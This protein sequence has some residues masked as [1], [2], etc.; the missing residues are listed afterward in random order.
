[1]KKIVILLLLILSAATGNAQKVIAKANIN[2]R[3]APSTDSRLL[4]QIPK[5]TVV[6]LN[7]CESNWCEVSVSGHSGYVARQYTVSKEAQHAD[8]YQAHPTGPVN[9]YTNSRGNVVQ[10]PTHY[11]AP[12]EGAT[13][14]CNDGTYS[15]SQ[16]R[17][18]TCSHHGGVRR[19]MR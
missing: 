5:G 19:W 10:S 17:R 4:Y 11:D 3:S 2:L 1:M 7:G 16:S 8:R 9:H 15:F 18:G 6:E 13:A 14:Q 12:P